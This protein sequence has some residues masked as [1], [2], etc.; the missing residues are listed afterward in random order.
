M[1]LQADLP[2][3]E[4][5]GIWPV[6]LSY[7]S[8]ATVAAFAAAR[9]ITFPLLADEGSVVIRR[10]GLLN[11]AIA[12]EHPRHGVAC[13]ATYLLDQ[14]GRVERAILH[15][16]QTV[17]DSWPTALHGAVEL[18]AN[19]PGP[20]VRHEAAGVAITVS[21]DSATYAPRQRVGVRARV[22]IADG[23]HLY[24]RPL[25]P[26]YTPLTLTVEAP[27]GMIVEAVADPPPTLLPLPALGETLPVYTGAVDL[28]AYVTGEEVREDVAIA[29][30]LTWQVCT[31]TDCLV[32]Q[33]T[34]VS[35]PLRYRP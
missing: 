19:A 25:P 21:L 13:P 29:V 34:T 10:L 1:Q 5:A 12:T 18:R 2:A 23:A 30:T 8:Q 27:V 3:L 28:S 24:G 31:E 22:L 7:D 6:A 17:R 11:T 20:S 26:G 33:T 9:G 35:L 4:A 15:A 14:N 16:S 32:P